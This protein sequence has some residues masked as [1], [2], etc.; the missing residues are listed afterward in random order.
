MS[1]PHQRSKSRKSRIVVIQIELL[2]IVLVPATYLGQAAV[3]G[4]SYRALAV[5]LCLDRS[6][7]NER[8][9][10]RASSRGY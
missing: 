5:G 4:A 3:L 8:T 6:Y 10:R 2:A 7:S 9:L 1:R